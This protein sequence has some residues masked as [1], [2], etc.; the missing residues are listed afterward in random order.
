M[1]LH[2]LSPLASTIAVRCTSI[3]SLPSLCKNLPES[4]YSAIPHSLKQSSAKRN[5][6]EAIIDNLM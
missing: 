6:V 1:D 5:K 3:A 2:V 4:K